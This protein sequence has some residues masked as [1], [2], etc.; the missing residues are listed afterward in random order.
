MT[1]K[2]KITPESIKKRLEASA[3][4]GRN[5]RGIK[6]KSTIDREK[7]LQLAKDIVAGRT[8]RLIDTQTLL[9]MGT[10]KVFVIRY[11]MIGKKKVAKKP[12]L[13]TGEEQ[14][15]NALHYE[16]A[17]GESP[18]DND[19]Y[20]FVTTKDPDNQAINSLLDRTYGRSTENK[21]VS[22]EKGMGALLDEIED[23]E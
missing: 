5:K 9:A 15:I 12:E 19:E 4:G 6:N 11:E 10:I 8:R 1:N 2:S 17:D 21:V 14:I 20:Y 7:V 23:E 22:I 16:Y 18:N 13:V 3:K